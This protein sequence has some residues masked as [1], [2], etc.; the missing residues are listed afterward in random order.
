MKYDGGNLGAGLALFSTDRPRSFVDANNF[1]TDEGKDRHQ[2]AELTV[3]GQPT[4][5]VRVLGGLTFL[6]AEQ[7]KTGAATTDGK[8]VIGVPRFRSTMGVEWDIPGVQGLSVDGRMVHT[9]SSYADSA[10]TLRVPSWTRFAGG[11]IPSRQS[12]KP[13][14][15]SPEPNRK[16][17]RPR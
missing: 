12:R 2:G 3:Y 1:F 4:S 17:M 9:G 15:H 14:W 8:R 11:A 7:R 5:G 10:N 13:R 6:D 16:P